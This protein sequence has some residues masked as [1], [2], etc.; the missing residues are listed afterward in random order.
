MQL[1]C[2]GLPLV[3]KVFPSTLHL[4]PS[5]TL[6]THFFK[7]VITTSPQDLLKLDLPLTLA[8]IPC[9]VY[10]CCPQLNHCETKEKYYTFHFGHFSPQNRY[11]AFSTKHICGKV[12]LYVKFGSALKAAIMYS[13]SGYSVPACT[14]RL[15]SVISVML[16]CSTYSC[17]YYDTKISC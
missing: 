1:C 5:S 6:C 15:F 8:S 17:L 12:T 9:D 16:F 7:Q 13:F 2:S 11:A 3:L 14:S 4:D 10:P